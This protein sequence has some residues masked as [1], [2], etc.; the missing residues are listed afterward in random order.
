MI[1]GIIESVFA[2]KKEAQIPRTMVYRVCPILACHNPNVIPV[3]RI[4]NHEPYFLISPKNI[5]L[6]S[7]SSKNGAK[8][9][10]P[11]IFAIYPNKV[12]SATREITFIF[13]SEISSIIASIN[14]DK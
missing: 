5:P 13:E 4:A 7:N 1:Q 2:I 3:T 14:E 6:K 10:I 12:G 11:T 8:R 9:N